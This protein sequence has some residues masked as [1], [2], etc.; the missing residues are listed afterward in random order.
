MTGYDRYRYN[1]FTDSFIEEDNNDRMVQLSDFTTVR[2][3]DIEN[4]RMEFVKLENELKKYKKALELMAAWLVSGNGADLCE[5]CIGE[6]QELC[7]GYNRLHNTKEECIKTIVDYYLVE[8][9]MIK[10]KI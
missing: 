1:P 9:M 5:Y 7:N 2:M 10:E 8:A 3:S 6:Q 4:T